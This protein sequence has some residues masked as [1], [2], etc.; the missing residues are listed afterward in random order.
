MLLL[1]AKTRFF[2]FTI[3]NSW[4]L[5]NPGTTVLRLLTSSKRFLSSGEILTGWSW[6][7]GFRVN[8][9]FEI[10]DLV[11]MYFGTLSLYL[12]RL[13]KRWSKTTKSRTYRSIFCLSAWYN[14][15][16]R[17]MLLLPDV[18]LPNS[19]LFNEK[20]VRVNRVVN[21]MKHLL[22]IRHKLDKSSNQA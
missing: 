14:V 2:F 4:L 11:G 17:I 21:Q 10:G 12:T 1:E 3:T 9:P 7:S 22:G 13:I 19:F 18:F 20:L 5:L 6:P 16:S 15:C 8:D